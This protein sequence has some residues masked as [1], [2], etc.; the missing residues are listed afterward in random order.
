MQA[1]AAV[2]R[3]HVAADPATLPVDMADGLFGDRLCNV[4]SIL[5]RL[6]LVNLEKLGFS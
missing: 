2:L 4:E 3:A 1:E 6:L 5:T